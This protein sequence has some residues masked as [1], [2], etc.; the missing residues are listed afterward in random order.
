MV[1]RAD[2][3]VAAAPFHGHLTAIRTKPSLA[4]I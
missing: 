1:Q 4:A 3:R 2:P